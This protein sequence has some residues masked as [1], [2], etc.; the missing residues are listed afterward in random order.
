MDP[1]TDIRRRRQALG[2]PV[3]ELAREVGRS[4]AT[5]SRIERGRVRPSYE[6]AQAIFGYLERQEGKASPDLKG[7]DVMNPQVV[8]LDAESTLGAAATLM[9][10][11]GFSQFPVVDQGR[12]TGSLSDVAL[13]RALS[14]PRRRRDRV[15]TVQEAAYPQVGEDF[16]ADL[17]AAVLSRYPAVLIVERGEIR[18]IVTKMDLI[19]GLRLTAL[20]R[21]PDP[22]APV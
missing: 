7:K 1:L 13:L 18:G 11:R 19:R 9:E 5:I 15:R 2:I 8:S 10:R 12:V 22:T 14:D 21:R 6:L 20:R 17:L 16:P 3:R 4:V